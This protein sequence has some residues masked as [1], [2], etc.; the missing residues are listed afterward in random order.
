MRATPKRSTQV[1]RKTVMISDQSGAEIR[2]GKGAKVTIK[3]DDLRKGARELDLTEEE[4][5]K[6]G[7]RAVKRRGRRPRATS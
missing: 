6:L 1:A 5:E 4:A 2:E 3:F 7:G